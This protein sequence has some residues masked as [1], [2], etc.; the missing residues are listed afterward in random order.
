MSDFRVTSAAKLLECDQQLKSDRKHSEAALKLQVGPL[1][2]TLVD[3]KVAE[4]L[5]NFQ[6]TIDT[7]VSAAFNNKFSSALTQFDLK[8]DNRLTSFEERTTASFA[9]EVS[10][11]LPNSRPR[12]PGAEKNVLGN[13]VLDAE[14][15]VLGSDKPVPNTDSPPG[16]VSSIRDNHDSHA[17]CQR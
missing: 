9:S 12:G 3:E 14:E 7:S 16:L 5:Q 6:S 17:I 15:N 13:V 11:L 1:L 4:K 2:S 10:K 8:Q